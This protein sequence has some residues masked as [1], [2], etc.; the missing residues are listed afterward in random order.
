[1]ASIGCPAM[2]VSYYQWTVRNIPEDGRSNLHRDGS[3]TLGGPET[4]TGQ[5]WKFGEAR[6]DVRQTN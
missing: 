2:S 1:M 4:G 3:L 6:H 5:M